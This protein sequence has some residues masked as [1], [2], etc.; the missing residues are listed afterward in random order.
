L[1]HA[2]YLGRELAKAEFSL[3]YGF[4]YIQ[5]KSP[6]KMENILE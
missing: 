6:G 3:K 4:K 1:S 5:D 2:A